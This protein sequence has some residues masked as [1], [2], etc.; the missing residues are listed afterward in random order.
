[1]LNL[2]R[3]PFLILFMCALFTGWLTAG[4]FALSDKLLQKV[5]DYYG[6][7]AKERLLE[8]QDVVQQNQQLSD[9]EKLELVN[10]FFNRVRFINDIDHWRQEDYWATPVEFL[11]TNGGD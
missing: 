11:S 4:N 8:W 6:E 2:V 9:Q 7:D 1:M 3:R 10:D 5:S